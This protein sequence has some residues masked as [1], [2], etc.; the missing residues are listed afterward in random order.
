MASHNKAPLLEKMRRL[1]AHPST[2]D[3]TRS[4][5]RARLDVLAPRRPRLIPGAPSRRVSDRAAPSS[6][7]T[8]DHHKPAS[9]QGDEPDACLNRIARDAYQWSSRYDSRSTHHDLLF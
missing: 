4:V 6:V 9:Q 1:A 7:V 2:D 3:A 8:A 5:V